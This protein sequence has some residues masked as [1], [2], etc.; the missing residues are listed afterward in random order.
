MTLLGSIALW[1]AL[2]MGLWGAVT[3]FAGG[4]QGRTDLQRSARHAVFA[5][6]AALAVAVIC[7]EV[8]IFQHDFNV[9]YVAGRTSRN[10]PTFYLWSS[11][12]SGQEGSLL[13]WATVLS[14]FASLAQVL[15]S[16]RHRAYL[17]FVAAVTCLVTTFF[18]S[19]MLFAPANPF[20]RLPY[21]PVDGAGMNPQLQN[22]G[23]VFHPPML[24]L[25]YISV[26]IPF[27]FAIAA[28]MSKKLDVDWLVAIR[29]WT[30]L[31]WL[32]LSIGLLIGM[33]WAYVELGWGGYWAWDPVE[34][35]ALL[36]WLTMTAFLHSV[37]IQEKRGMLK[38]WNLALILGSWLLSIF[39]TFITR[40]G[41]IASVHSFTQS[42]VGYFFLVF[43]VFAGV[44]T[45]VLYAN[46]LPLLEAESTLESM[47]SREAS[48]LFNN[49]LFLGIAFSVLWGTLFPI[50]SE[51]V[52]GT[53][54]TV[55]PPFF[56]QVNIPLGLALLA[57]TGIGPL[58]AW[59]RASM[60]NLQ[61]Q[62][63]VP[64][65]TGVFVLLILLVAGMRDVGALMA[66][67]LG[68]FVMGT[69]T[70]EFA[71]GTSARHR[72][73]AE[74]LALAAVRLVGRNR[75]RYGG[76]IVHTG[77][78]L[79]FVAF[80][81]MAFK[82]ETQATLRPGE[83]VTLRSPY[84]HVY[85]FTHV[86]VSQYDAL[87][88]RVT[89]AL[90]EVSRDGKHVGRLKTEKRQHVDALGRNTFEPSTEVGIRSGL[91][92]DLYVVLGG[93]VNGTEQAVYRFTI[94]PLVW[95]VW[96]G[97]YVLV[98]G[99]LIVLWPGGGPPAVRRTQAG[100]AVKLEAKT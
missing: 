54:V 40:S 97:G 34:N 65:T 96:F 10:L 38:K 68:G 84:G 93:L 31:S 19:V 81:G 69:V 6:F 45:F 3:G 88:R 58:I 83:S 25:G 73:Y 37:M 67:A 28:L 75:R 27:A 89:A 33:W 18:V 74:P 5:M 2:L 9:A 36:P 62:F 59:R 79:L 61:R 100:Y 29:K 53:K 87:N 66:I 76:Y 72:Q 41:V 82:T 57:L 86:S 7:L 21:T 80:A 15:T 11:L 51:W 43:L 24:Y 17:P 90:V 8:A 85:T 12:Y 70:Q 92:E 60:P 78:V 99:G 22:P 91:R 50:L 77:M 95:W 16:A 94:N 71:R 39:G 52:K 26:T 55:G 32:F 46:R 30:L 4:L 13:F 98:A 47:V 14:L 56:N 48:F 63:A 64:A 42:N 49:L 23:M 35:V 44:A 20:A 1:L